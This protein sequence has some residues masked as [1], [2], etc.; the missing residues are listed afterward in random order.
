MLQTN[1]KCFSGALVNTGIRVFQNP[2]G[3]LIFF[4]RQL[5]SYDIQNELNSSDWQHAF[6]S[7]NQRALL[8]CVSTISVHY[9][10]EQTLL[11]KEPKK[12]IPHWPL[13]CGT[14]VLPRVH[15]EEV[16]THFMIPLCALLLITYPL[17]YGH[18]EPHSGADRPGITHSLGS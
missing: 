1:P 15:T 2:Q 5:D 8:V 11:T 6:V 16:Q 13:T 7:R 17:S 10:E 4:M 14:K 9:T 12:L 18:W 3:L